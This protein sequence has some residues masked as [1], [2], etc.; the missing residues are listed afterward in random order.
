MAGN[1]LLLILDYVFHAGSRTLRVC[2]LSLLILLSGCANLSELG[3]GHLTDLF[4]SEE[5][6]VEIDEA[7]I[8]ALQ[9][10]APINPLWQVKLAESKTAVFLPVYDNGALYVADEDGRLVKL[11]PVTGREI[12]RVET[13]SQLSGGVGAGGGMILLG[14]YK[15]EVLAFD[16]AGNALWQSRVPGEV[17][18]PPKTDS[19]IVVV[20]TGD[21]KLFG[22]NATDGK[23]IWSYQSVTPP[24]TVRSFVGVSITRGAVFAGFPGGKLIALDLLTGNVGW[25]ETVSQPHGVTELER[26]TDISSLP[27]VDENQVCAVAY[28]GRAACFEISSGNQ[29]WARDA[30]SSMGMVIDNHHVYISEEHGIVAAY[31]K[32]SGTAVWKRGKLGSRKL[33]GL[34][35]VRGNRLVVGDDQGF[36]TLINRQ[37]G[38]LLAR[39]P[40]DGGIILSRAEYLPDGFVV[41]TLKGGVFA[42]S[43]Q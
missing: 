16:E 35:I 30:S 10:L 6:E 5:D 2:I 22:L 42:F 19:G 36:V 15:G 1:I 37:D 25:E 33:S 38:S 11:D 27:I 39:S 3:G 21:S 31:D 41:Q 43:L 24:L 34:M 7:E 29:I 9:T 12:W 14:T 13:K 32:S 23:R 8:A 26:M 40:T 18:S 4:S 17:L 20:R 28:R